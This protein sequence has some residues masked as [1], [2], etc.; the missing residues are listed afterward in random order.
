M[1][2][3]VPSNTRIFPNEYPG[4]RSPLLSENGVRAQARAKT[5]DQV[6]IEVFP[7]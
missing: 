1:G 6:N 5:L 4:S 2:Q 3:S 7:K